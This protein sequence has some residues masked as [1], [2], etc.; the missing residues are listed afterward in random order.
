VETVEN[1]MEALTYADVTKG[2]GKN[3][4]L[5]REL[6]KNAVVAHDKQLMKEIKDDL[7]K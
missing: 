6:A 1:S 3:A 2:K 4:T 5:K 7:I